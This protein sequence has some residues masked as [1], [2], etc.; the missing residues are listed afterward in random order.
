MISALDALVFLW[1]EVLIALI[2]VL[3]RIRRPRE[4]ESLIKK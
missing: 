4:T 1:P 3:N 2:Y